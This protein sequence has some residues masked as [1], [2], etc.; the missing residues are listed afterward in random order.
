[1]RIL[2]WGLG[3]VGTV[4]SVCLAAFGY[5]VIGIDP[6][7]DK[8]HAINNGYVAIKE[9][10]LSKMVAQACQAG[11]LSAITHGHDLVSQADM[12]L[13]CVGTPSDAEGNPQLNYVETVCRDIGRGLKSSSRYHVVVLRSTVFPGTCRNLVGGVLAEE[14]GKKP[15]DD[16]GL[17]MNPEF[18]RES[19]AVD[20]FN[21]PPY[22]IIGALDERSGE[23]VASLYQNLI[24][25]IKHVTL[26]EAELL[27]I[28][29]NVFHALKIGF[30]NEIGRICDRLGIDSHKIMD[31][32]CS[33][34]KLNISPAYLRPGFAFGGSCL[35]KDLRLLTNK[36]RRLGAEVP[37]LDAIL[38][39]NHVQITL[40]R[41][42]LHEMGAKKIGV[43]GLSFKPGTDDIRE[44]PIIDL[45]RALWQDGMD[46]LVYD[47]DIN[48]NEMIGSNRDYLERQ[49]PQINKILCRSFEEMVKTSDAIVVSQKRL[50]YVDTLKKFNDQVTV[51]DL[52]RLN[53]D[54]ESLGI[55]NYIG[56]S[57]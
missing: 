12:S 11:R 24:A 50:E 49:L 13:I 37:I 40:A 28:T 21:Q 15:G 29:N 6:N 2:V 4:T 45:I 22:T 51:L 36:A 8:V 57:W 18:L 48:L 17:V 26:E 54:T 9:P 30:G 38:P 39:S 46:V 23:T 5:E 56:I 27:K 35:P 31:L 33:D 25:P 52:V 3:Y 47:P 20:D 43:L 16:F 41:I 10:G 7:Q 32:V 34:S 53:G 1:M 14:S 44:S 19:S 55:N 42:K